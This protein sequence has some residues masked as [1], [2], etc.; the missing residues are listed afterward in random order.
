MMYNSAARDAIADVKALVS[1]HPAKWEDLPG[2]R[3][4]QYVPFT[5]AELDD[6]PVKGMEASLDIQAHGTADALMLRTFAKEMGKYLSDG[7]KK[8]LQ[9]DTLISKWTHKLSPE[10]QNAVLDAVVRK[11]PVVLISGQLP[12]H[13]GRELDGAGVAELGPTDSL[14]ITGHGSP[15]H[16]IICVSPDVT[17]GEK[18]TA[19]DTMRRMQQDLK[20]PQLKVNLQDAELAPKLKLNS[21]GSSGKFLAAFV[22]EAETNHLDVDVYAYDM[23]IIQNWTPA[24]ALSHLELG[25]RHVA[26][27][28]PS[29]DV[30]SA[31]DI[32]QEAANAARQAKEG[33]KTLAS[34]SAGD[35]LAREVELLLVMEEELAE[36]VEEAET[37][38]RLTRES[39]W[40][41]QLPG[42]EKK[43]A[44][45]KA[46]LEPVAEKLDQLY[47]LDAVNKLLDE[48]AQDLNLPAES[49]KKK[50]L[51]T[52]GPALEVE[53]EKLKVSVLHKASEHRPKV[54]V[55]EALKNSGA[56]G[57]QPLSQGNAVSHSSIKNH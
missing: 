21:C 26:F 19:A 9:L 57:A 47:P 56:P 52:L 30:K 34:M 51:R 55:R 27:N 28:G 37:E 45:A 17:T 53:A 23:D 5:Q 25:S 35:E 46:K 54:S 39:E 29:E 6:A 24:A 22:T 10:Q 31:V 13:C 18:L 33:G 43:L 15:A 2:R 49:L 11:T 41:D 36:A 42:A 7:D 3:S 16:D 14:N 20:A 4:V 48:R 38:L 1:Q 44:D 8:D 50:T 40:H 12:T 32:M